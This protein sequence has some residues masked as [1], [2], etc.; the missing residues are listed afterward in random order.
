[1][2]WGA[3]HMGRAVTHMGR[4]VTHLAI[5]QQK[6]L[7]EEMEDFQSGLMNGE[8]NKSAWFCYN[9]QMLQQLKRGGCIQTYKKYFKSYTTKG[10]LLGMIPVF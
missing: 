4:A 9:V 6:N 8:Y 3:T 7:V 2:G 5:T 10:R 1:M